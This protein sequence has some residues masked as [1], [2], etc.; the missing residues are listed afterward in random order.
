MGFTNFENCQIFLGKFKYFDPTIWR[1]IVLRG[2]WQGFYTVGI[3][4]F[5]RLKHGACGIGSP[6]QQKQIEESHTIPCT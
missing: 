3:M 2:P 6:T 4:E 5:E 1:E